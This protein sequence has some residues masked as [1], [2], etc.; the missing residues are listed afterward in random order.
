MKPEF[1]LTQLEEEPETQFYNLTFSE[2]Q[3]L[4]GKSFIVII[5][6]AVLAS[7]FIAFNNAAIVG[8]GV[9]VV[10]FWITVRKTAN[11]RADKPLYYHRHIK[12]YKKPTLFIQPAMHYQIER[13]RYEHSKK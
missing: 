7:F 8:M 4:F 9:G 12:M 1:T 10:Y 2:V 3:G 13:T 11:N 5:L 6:S